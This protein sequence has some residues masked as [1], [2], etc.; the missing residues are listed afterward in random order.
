MQPPSSVLP[1]KPNKTPHSH[2]TPLNLLHSGAPKHSTQSLKPSSHHSPAILMSI[3]STPAAT[4]PL[5]L[6]AYVSNSMTSHF[7]RLNGAPRQFAT[8]FATLSD[9]MVRYMPGQPKASG[10][11]VTL[12]LFKSMNS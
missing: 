4:L 3:C 11:N 12:Q 7:P 5:S 6:K 10:A 9:S 8:F 2:N 1:N